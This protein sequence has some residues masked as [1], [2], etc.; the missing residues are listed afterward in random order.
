MIPN[1]M[2]YM[3]NNETRVFDTDTETEKQMKG[4]FLWMVFALTIWMVLEDTVWRLLSSMSMF[5][6]R[7]EMMIRSSF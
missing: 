3:F 7:S 6:Q 4:E 2:N 5:S 1:N